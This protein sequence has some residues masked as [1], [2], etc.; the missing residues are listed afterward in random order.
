MAHAAGMQ[1]ID[2]PN[3][4]EPAIPTIVWYPSRDKPTLNT[5]GPFDL[6]VAIDGAIAGTGLPLVVI[7]HGTGGSNLS[8]YDTAIA[9]ADAGFVVAAVEH[10]ADNYRDGS[11]SFTS[12][13]FVDRPGH[14]SR[15]IDT[16]LRDWKGHATVD[17]KRIGVF[18]HSA[19]GATALLATGGRGEFGRLPAFCRE[20]PADWGC[21]KAAERTG[22]PDIAPDAT[23]A[24]A[25][26]TRIRAIAL[27]APALAKIFPP[28][29]LDGVKIPVQLWVAGKDDIVTDAVSLRTLLPTPPT[30]RPVANGGHFAFLA[31][32][33]AFLA[34]IAAPICV[35]PKGFAR[36]AFLR[37]FQRGLIGFFKDKLKGG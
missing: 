35:D 10:T 26:D 20:H 27:A 30:Y 15:T 9:L 11:N 14:V 29:G 24:L 19:G 31:P 17:P 23:V 12:R 13:N 25:P 18:G 6:N 8:H 2:V 28:H 34:K 32:C 36:T 5:F 1:R 37:D 7:S 33:S 3:G 22:S 16:L 21:R 4:N